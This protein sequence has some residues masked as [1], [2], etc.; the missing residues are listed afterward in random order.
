M[1]KKKQKFVKREAANKLLASK[2]E[3]MKK[4][5]STKEKREAMF[6]KDKEDKKAEGIDSKVSKDTKKEEKK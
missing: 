2:E 4:V 6:G 5:R 1:E 3:P